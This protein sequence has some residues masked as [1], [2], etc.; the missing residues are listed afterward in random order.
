MLWRDLDS[1]SLFPPKFWAPYL[2][3]GKGLQLFSVTFQMEIAH[4]VTAARDP[5]RKMAEGQWQTVGCGGGWEGNISKSGAGI[6]LLGCQFG[7]EASTGEGTAP[8]H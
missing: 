7:R 6:K 1:S 5:T 4:E 8:L 2:Q 3:N